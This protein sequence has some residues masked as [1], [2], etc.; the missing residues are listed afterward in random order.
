M[1]LYAFKSLYGYN[2][3]LR[4]GKI[5][6]FTSKETLKYVLEVNLDLVEIMS[7]FRLHL[8]K[9]AIEYNRIKKFFKKYKFPEDLF[10]RELGL[11]RF[12]I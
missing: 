8:T 6:E 2:S 3:S 7:V 10:K 12:T 9:K 11:I 1:K 5:M 4:E